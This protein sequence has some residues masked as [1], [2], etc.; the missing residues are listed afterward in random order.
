MVVSQIRYRER[1]WTS[2]DSFTEWL[3]WLGDSE[4]WTMDQASAAMKE[5]GQVS[6][7]EDYE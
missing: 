1:G 4:A 2:V 7:E 5:P 3:G 6:S